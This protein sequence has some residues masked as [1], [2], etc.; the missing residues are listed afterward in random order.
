VDVGVEAAID[1]IE[2]AAAGVDVAEGGET[3]SA[4]RTLAAK[5]DD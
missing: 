2:G 3:D 5:S 1:G 4:P